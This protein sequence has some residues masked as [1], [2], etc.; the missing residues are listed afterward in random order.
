MHQA[1]TRVG[2]SQALAPGVVRGPHERDQRH[3]EEDADDHESDHRHAVP[4]QP[5]PGVL[6]QGDLFR[7]LFSPDDMQLLGDLNRGRDYCRH[8]IT[9]SPSVPY[10]RV[11][12]WIK[13]VD[14]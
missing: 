4:P 6:P 1:W 10:P 2:P 9:P 5:P 7:E 8:L 14:G 11:E 13:Q 12:N 3:E